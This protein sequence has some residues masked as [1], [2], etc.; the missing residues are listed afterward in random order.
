MPNKPIS[1]NQLAAY[2]QTEIEQSSGWAGSE[3]RETIKDSLNYL[4]M[5]LKGDEVP[6]RSQVQSGD[7]ANI[8]DHIMAEL[9]PMYDKDN[10]VKFGQEG[11][12]DQ[13]YDTVTEAINWYWSNRLRA[14]N[15]LD[16][17]VQ[18]AVLTRN[19]YLKV[20]FEE[21]YGLPYEETITGDELQVGAELEQLEQD[22]DVEVISREIVQ[23]QVIETVQGIGPDGV[24]PVAV[25][26]ETSPVI[27]SLQLL[28]KPHLQEV[29]IASVA[30]EDMFTSRD[31]VDTD[32][33]APRFVGHRRREPRYEFKKLGFNPE[34]IDRIPAV[35]LWDQDVKTSRKVDHNTYSRVAATNDGELVDVWECYYK[36]DQ[37]GDNIPELHKVYYAQTRELLSLKV[38]EDEDGE[39]IYETSNEIVRVR[40]FA[41]G[42]CLKVSHRHEGRSPAY[43]KGRQTEDIKRTLQRQ[44]L[45]NLYQAN[46]QKTIIGPGVDTDSLEQTEVG[47]YVFTQ[48]M[49]SVRPYP[50]NPIAAE[51]LAAL[52]YFDKERDETVGSSVSRSTQNVPV[53][54]AAHTTE[55][56]MSA[57]EL[58]TS[59]FAANLKQSLI[60]DTFALLHQQMQLLPGKVAFEQGND[61]SET[62]PRLWI[63]R[64][65]LTVTLG[66]SRG[67]RA[68]RQA[69]LA[70]VIGQQEKDAQ[71]GQMNILVDHQAMY[72]A[73]RDLTAMH[74]L[75]DPEQYWVNPESPG[76][77]QQIAQ[78]GQM[79]AQRMEMEAQQARSMLEAPM[80][81]SRMQEETKRLQA[82]IDAMED[83]RDRLADMQKH[84]D[85]LA[86]KYVEL[87]Q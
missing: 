47:G 66:L 26:V 54:Q 58:L 33:Q 73:R 46:D 61:W 12:D 10:L 20:Y 74:G 23:Q 42:S 49:D 38:G 36:I 63:Q 85:D 56:V 32:M 82:Q 72:Q 65:R 13:D 25:E 48:N 87:E 21:S 55:R 51:S 22:N 83:Q 30:P 53:N 57:Q 78:N 44:L 19:G 67:E 7:V 31:A 18:D 5:R 50:H 70:G 80:V 6:G 79:A 69:A 84:Y 39:P 59:M 77:Q 43:D 64:N 9:Q 71:N 4:H 2:L 8:L 35:S 45:D 41:G 75:D 15:A 24:T 34:Q 62:E 76:A 28:I 60:R 86:Q 27:Y 3:W 17:S 81:I 16:S 68:R 11:P 52:A 40:P 14:F 37:D 1:D 29:K